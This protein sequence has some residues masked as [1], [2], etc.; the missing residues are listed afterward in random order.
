MDQPRH[1][2]VSKSQPHIHTLKKHNLF[3]DDSTQKC[4]C[5]RLLTRCATCHKPFCSRCDPAGTR[6]MLRERRKK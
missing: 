6:E 2:V 1:R 5:G 4:K 3:M